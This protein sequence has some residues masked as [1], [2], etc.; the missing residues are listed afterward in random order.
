MNRIAQTCLL[1]GLAGWIAAAQPDAFAA[2]KPS[3]KKPTAA[4]AAKK[5]GI[6][7]NPYRGAIAVDAATGS[8]LFEDKADAKGYPAS[9]LKLM[10][11]LII[12]EKIQQGQLNLNDQVPASAKASKTGGSQVWLAEKES[13]TLDE[14]LYALMVQSANDAAVALA[15]KVAGSTEAFIDLM[16]QRAQQLGM[17]STRFASVHGLPPSGGQEHDVTTARDLSV[18]CRELLKHKETLRYTSMRERPFRPDQ[19]KKTVIMRTHNHLLGSVEGCD[20]LKTGYITEAGYSIAVTAQRKGRRVIAVVLGSADRKVRDA[21]AAELL[22]KG[23]LALPAEPVAV[24]APATPKPE[25]IGTAQ[26]SARTTVETKPAEQKSESRSHYGAFMA[27]GIVAISAL[28]A[29]WWMKK[30]HWF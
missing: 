13:F 9:V 19:G 16:N 15:E 3:T 23:F 2:S 7:E 10:D 29:A 21:K 27:L 8:V 25:P 28:A 12:L 22:S 14:M 24:A 20:G 17:T 11:L 4:T 18:L 1:I 26:P 5:R 6:A 30:N